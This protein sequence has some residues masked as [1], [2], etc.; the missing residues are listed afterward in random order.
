MDKVSLN[1]PE[2]Q[3]RASSTFQNLHEDTLF[4][5]VTLAT[6]DDQQIKAH[7]NILGSVSPFF[8][9]ILTKHVHQHPLLYLK[10]VQGEILKSI[11]A[12]I[13]IGYVEISQ[14]DLTQFIDTAKDLEIEIPFVDEAGADENLGVDDMGNESDHQS[15][16]PLNLNQSMTTDEHYGQ[17]MI[18]VKSFNKQILKNEDD[19]WFQN[20][21]ALCSREI[22]REKGLFDCS[23][24]S[25]QTKSKTDFKRHLDHHAGIKY[26]C[27]QCGYS[28]TRTTNLNKHKLS[29]HTEG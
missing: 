16:F 10:G 17:K 1:L 19:K 24:C 5:D 26:N 15:N 21:D 13:Y 23:T 20:T 14:T 27:D 8:R 11:L 2:Y 22:T 4:V 3:L 9:S 12:F 25:F 18:N 6:D 29:K 28:A 7:K